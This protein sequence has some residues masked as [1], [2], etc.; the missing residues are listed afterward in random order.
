MERLKV[1]RQ[2]FSIGAA[3]AGGERLL[4]IAGPCVIEER[5]MTLRIAE[6]LAKA[7]AARALPFVFKASYRKANRSS[8]RS[9]AGLP[10]DR[11]LAVLAEVRDTLGLPVLTDVHEPDEVTAA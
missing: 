10:L 6:T 9:F 5:D 1:S 7:C 2:R 3:E 11:A 4:V 8:G